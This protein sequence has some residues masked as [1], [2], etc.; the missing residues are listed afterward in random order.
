MFKH[1]DVNS[2]HEH[3][4]EK[5]IKEFGMECETLVRA[6]YREQ[7]LKL[8]TNAR[9]LLYVPMLACNAARETLRDLCRY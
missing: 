5:L 3:S 9:V 7:K 8:E 1:N 4:I 6:T 2:A